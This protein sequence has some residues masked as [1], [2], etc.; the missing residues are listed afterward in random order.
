M[1][2]I[3][4]N[5]R[6]LIATLAASTAAAPILFGGQANSQSTS[7]DA[8]VF[9]VNRT[10]SEWRARL[11]DQEY[12]ILRDRGTEQRRS[13]PL[14]TETGAGLYACRG[15]DLTLFD[16]YW[17][18]VLD[19]GWVFFRQSEPLSILTSIDRLP[20]Q[21]LLAGGETTMAPELSA[22]DIRDLDALDGIEA[23]CRRCG[24]PLGHLITTSGMLLYCV[25][26]TALEFTPA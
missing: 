7:G 8:F 26:G 12:T 23:V 6:R 5:R 2:Q 19:M 22:E 11:T 21:D 25:N 1:K 4:T 10:E 20:Y 15:C 9:E 13:S 18:V 16:G 3:D 14:W 24:S 17:K